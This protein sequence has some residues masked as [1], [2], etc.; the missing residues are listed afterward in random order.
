[1]A[2][3][4]GFILNPIEVAGLRDVPVLAEL[5]GQV[6]PCGAKR[7]DRCAGQKMIERFFLD[8]ID[9][10]A[11]RTAVGGE[12]D[13]VVLPGAHKAQAALAFVQLAIARTDVALDAPIRQSM[14]VAGWVSRSRLIHAWSVLTFTESDM[15]ISRR[16]GKM[17]A[18]PRS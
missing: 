17:Q 7:Q 15:V 8:R 5:A 9:A 18:G 1:M 10:K 13:L 3:G 4:G 16:P 14:P 11:R 12:H 6:A 2:L